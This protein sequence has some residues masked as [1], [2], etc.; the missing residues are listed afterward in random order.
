MILV[1]L[2][3]SFKDKIGLM[4]KK[5]AEDKHSNLHCKYKFSPKICDAQTHRTKINTFPLKTQFNT[6]KAVFFLLAFWH[7]AFSLRYR[8]ES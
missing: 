7:F 5:H 4:H 1:N 6:N 8:R 3:L 2:Y